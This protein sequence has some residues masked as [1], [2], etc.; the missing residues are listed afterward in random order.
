M[1]WALAWG[2]QNHM[3]HA[4][5]SSHLCDV[6]RRVDEEARDDRLPNGVTWCHMGSHGVTRGHT[7]SHG[8]DEEAC[9]HRLVKR[10]TA[11]VRRRRRVRARRRLQCLPVQ[12]RARCPGFGH[13]RRT[14]ALASEHGVP[15]RAIGQTH[16]ALGVRRAAVAR[17]SR[18]SQRQRCSRY[19]SRKS[20]AQIDRFASCPSPS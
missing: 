11:R 4:S 6:M 12:A 9:D 17:A 3:G 16:P 20:P 18:T 5:R 8:V 13:A 1:Q 7:G 19:I 15:Q 10:R 2:C 14:A